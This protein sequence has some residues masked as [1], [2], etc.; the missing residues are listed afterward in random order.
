MNSSLFNSAR[1]SFCWRALELTVAGKPFEGDK[2]SGCKTRTVPATVNQRLCRFII[3]A[4]CLK[5][6]GEGPEAPRLSW[7]SVNLACNTTEATA[8]APGKSGW[9]LAHVLDRYSIR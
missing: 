1:T 3:R 7:E 4:T 6:D 9:R 2:G 5:E 8:Y